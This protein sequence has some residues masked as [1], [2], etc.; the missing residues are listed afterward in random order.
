MS[1]LTT[2]Q[3]YYKGETEKKKLFNNMKNLGP[4]NTQ[5]K[6]NRALVITFGNKK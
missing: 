3:I 5:K 2:V 4:E 6:N 1:Q